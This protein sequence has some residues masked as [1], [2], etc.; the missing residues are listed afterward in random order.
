MKMGIFYICLGILFFVLGISKLS[1]SESKEKEDVVKVSNE[2]KSHPVKESKPS[3]ST[4]QSKIEYSPK[5]FG[6]GSKTSVMDKEEQ[7]A[8]DKG[9]DF[10][11]YI[12]DLC[13]SGGVRVREWHQGTV[14]PGGVLA[15]NALNPD[16]FL[17]IPRNGS[18]DIEFWLECKYRSHL[19]DAF[20]LK[21]S[22]VERYKEKQRSSKRK[23][24][25]VL[26]VG[27]KPS[28]P[29]D[30]YVFSVDSMENASISSADLASHKIKHHPNMGGIIEA[31]F[32]NDVFKKA[33]KKKYAQ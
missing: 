14:S 12:A 4:E 5:P 25:V 20:S 31:W 33:R 29:S 11:A 3:I 16:F 27:G 9:N 8:K 1:S 10:E 24:L 6:Q 32:I 15:E 19:G 18:S 22:Q 17:A 13:K 30:L 28:K 21:E 23:V 7:S 26:G 2:N